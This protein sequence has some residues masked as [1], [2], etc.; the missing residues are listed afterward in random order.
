MIKEKVNYDNMPLLNNTR[1][2]GSS[3]CSVKD[4]I[5]SG[6]GFVGHMISVP[7]IQLCHCSPKAAIDNMQ[8][9]GRGCVPTFFDLQ[10]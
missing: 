6:L 9:N 3:N 5:V 8:K 4:Q 7:P 2:A 10:K 1:G